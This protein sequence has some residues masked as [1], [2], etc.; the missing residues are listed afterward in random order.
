MTRQIVVVYIVSG[1]FA[2]DVETPPSGPCRCSSA[3]PSP[4]LDTA[5]VIG[6]GFD[7]VTSWENEKN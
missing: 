7:T 6:K 4:R 3:V 5:V 2:F 1:S